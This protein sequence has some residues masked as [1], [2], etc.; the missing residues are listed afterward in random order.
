[1]TAKMGSDPGGFNRAR[2]T[3]EVTV[4]D[5][6]RL[7]RQNQVN[8]MGI[9][10]GVPGLVPREAGGECRGRER[11]ALAR[12][13]KTRLSARF[14]TPEAGAGIGGG[15]ALTL[16]WLVIET[17]GF[18]FYLK[19]ELPPNLPC[20]ALDVAGR[21]QTLALLSLPSTSRRLACSY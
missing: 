18:N 17:K 11:G 13:K 7:P 3:G 6:T 19:N 1:M 20:G 8:S 21:P 12:A 9:L 10:V 16:T 5:S 2:G 15:T 4:A 14:S